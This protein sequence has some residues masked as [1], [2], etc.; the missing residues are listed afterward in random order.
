MKKRKIS[1]FLDRG[2]PSRSDI[3]NLREWCTDCSFWLLLIESAS[4]GQPC[5][6]NVLALLSPKLP[7]RTGT[8]STLEIYNIDFLACL[9]GDLKHSPLEGLDPFN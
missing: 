8:A 7:I 3:F 2:L 1:A 9:A 4:A 5:S 6:D